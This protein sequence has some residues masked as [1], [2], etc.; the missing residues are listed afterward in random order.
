MGNGIDST[1]AAPEFGS[2]TGMKASVR[3]EFIPVKA[4]PAQGDGKHFP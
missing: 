3:R 1:G 4:G 2:F